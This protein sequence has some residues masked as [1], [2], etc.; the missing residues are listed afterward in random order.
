MPPPYN[1]IERVGK[2]APPHYEAKWRAAG[3]Q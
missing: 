1:L 2:G 3:K